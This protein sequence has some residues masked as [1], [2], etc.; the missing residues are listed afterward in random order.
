M[1]DGQ[2]LWALVE[3]PEG[4]SDAGLADAVTEKLHGFHESLRALAINT[5][6]A[7]AS[8]RPH[9]VKIEFGLELAAGKDGIVAAL[10]SASGTASVK[11]SLRWTNA[12]RDPASALAAAAEQGSTDGA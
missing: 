9:D 12:E 4:A 3:V 11:V 7:V 2:A 10:A 6:S 1:P 5:R 8:A